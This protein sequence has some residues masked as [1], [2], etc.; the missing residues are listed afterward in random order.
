[1]ATCRNENWEEIVFEVKVS[2]KV[3]HRCKETWIP[4]LVY[5]AVAIKIYSA[6][7]GYTRRTKCRE[8]TMKSS[9]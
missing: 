3:Q 1:M 8:C 2:Y 5:V 7:T 6:S 4:A 9:L